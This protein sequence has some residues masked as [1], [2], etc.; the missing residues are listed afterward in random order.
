MTLCGKLLGQRGTDLAAAY[1]YDAHT[2]PPIFYTGAE[3]GIS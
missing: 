2:A 1:N 3:K